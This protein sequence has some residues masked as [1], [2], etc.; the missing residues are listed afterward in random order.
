[1]LYTALPGSKCL[2]L[3]VVS[4]SGQMFSLLLHHQVGADH[5]AIHSNPAKETRPLDYEALETVH[6]AENG[7][8]D[9]ETLVLTGWGRLL[10]L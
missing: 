10:E 5:G 8:V 2:F 6:L 4:L 9:K 7:A 1:M 3:A